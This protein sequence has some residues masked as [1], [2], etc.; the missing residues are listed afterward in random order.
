MTKVRTFLV[1]VGGAE[2]TSVGCLVFRHEEGFGSVE[3]GLISLA[4]GLKTVAEVTVADVAERRGGLRCSHCGAEQSSYT[5]DPLDEDDVSRAAYDALASICVE[6]GTFY[7]AFGDM[8]WEPWAE[9]DLGPVVVLRQYGDRILADVAM[10]E[11]YLVARPDG[12][13]LAPGRFYRNWPEYVDKPEGFPWYV[14]G[15]ARS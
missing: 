13:R 4:S 12:R 7:D 3:G 5:S 10:N 6:S 8:G 2:D 15:E 1:Y 11:D 14:D 9:S